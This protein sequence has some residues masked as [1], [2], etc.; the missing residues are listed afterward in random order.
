[1]SDPLN[2][3]LACG[4]CCDGTLIGHVQLEQEEIPTLKKLMDVE[5]ENGNG[6]FLQPCSKYCNGCT[7]Y[8]KRPK[9]C[10]S[11]NCDLLKSVEQNELSFDSAL[12]TVNAVKEMKK[13]IEKNIS[14]LQLDLKSQSFHFK[15]V[16]L[17]KLL[18]NK[19]TES[20]MTKKHLELTSDLNQLDNL[21]FQKFGVSLY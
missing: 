20:S 2:I 8:S 17:N 18:Q 11:F 16:E 14:I 15:M 6:F 7:I 10:D 12:E 21:F 19:K 3:C 4:L 13:A 9:Q 1:M 5:D